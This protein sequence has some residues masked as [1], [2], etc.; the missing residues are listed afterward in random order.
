MEARIWGALVLPLVKPRCRLGDK[1]GAGAGTAGTCHPEPLPRSRTR[2]LHSHEVR[3]IGIA[4]LSSA[5]N[6]TSLKGKGDG[7]CGLNGAAW[8]LMGTGPRY[9]MDS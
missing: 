9:P 1:A 2:L 4:S 7:P 8:P 5:P 6:K 3:G